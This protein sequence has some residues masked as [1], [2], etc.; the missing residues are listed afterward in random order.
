MWFSR[1]GVAALWQVSQV[2]WADPVC[3]TVADSRAVV[4]VGSP[5]R[6]AAYWAKEG[7]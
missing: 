3:G 7:V 6:R 4:Q 5:G 2:T 1:L